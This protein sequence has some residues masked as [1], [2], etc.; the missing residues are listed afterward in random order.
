[1]IISIFHLF[2]QIQKPASLKYDTR[3][4][5]IPVHSNEKLLK[6]TD[7]ALQIYLGNITEALASKSGDKSAGTQ[8]TKLQL[9]NYVGTICGSGAVAKAVAVSKLVS[10]LGSCQ[11]DFLQ[12][13]LDDLDQLTHKYDV[14]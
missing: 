1:M 14:L 10:G 12:G 5:G 7:T 13:G 9:L 6:M 8:R 4:L 11:L 2:L 3:S